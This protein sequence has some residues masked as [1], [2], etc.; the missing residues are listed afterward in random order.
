MSQRPSLT[1]RPILLILALTLAP[2]AASL[3]QTRVVPPANSYSP[4]QDVELGRKA[5]EET[6]KTL[7]P[8]RDDNITSFV[9]DIGRRLVAVIPSDLRHSEFSTRSKS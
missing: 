3:A 5:A 6:R 8:M 2:S 7:P 4:A 9:E 1:L